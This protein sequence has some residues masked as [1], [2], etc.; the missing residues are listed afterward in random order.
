MQAMARKDLS[1]GAYPSISKA[2]FF[3][4]MWFHV[5]PGHE[6]QFEAAA[7]AYGASAKRAGAKTGYRVYEIS[8]GA[9]GPVYLVISS[10]ESYAEF[11]Q[12][13]KAKRG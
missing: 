2:R 12:S 1:Y 8:A 11:D 4:M 6:S 5:R 7:K 3:E 9:P 10:V 13:P